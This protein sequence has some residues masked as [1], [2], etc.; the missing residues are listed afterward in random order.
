MDH[1]I[2]WGELSI[3]CNFSFGALYSD[4]PLTNI[5]VLPLHLRNLWNFNPMHVFSDSSGMYWRE[6]RLTPGLYTDGKFVYEAAY[7][8]TDGK[9]GMKPVSNLE[10]FLKSG[11]IKSEV[12]QDLLNR[13]KEDSPDVVVEE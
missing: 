10:S 2:L 13:L 7:R 3:I 6:R 5:L 11:T 1:A 8:Y 4:S 9:N 12:K